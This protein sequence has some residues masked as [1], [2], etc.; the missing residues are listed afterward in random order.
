M[1]FRFEADHT[2]LSKML[3]NCEFQLLITNGFDDQICCYALHPLYYD[4]NRVA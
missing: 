1:L 4:H 2:T 3:Y